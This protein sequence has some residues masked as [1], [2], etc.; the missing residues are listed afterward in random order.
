[1]RKF[2]TLFTISIAFS[3]AGYAQPCIP[4]AGGDG[5]NWGDD[6]NDFILLGENNT[7]IN[8]PGTG[9]DPS[10]QAYEDYT[11][12]PAV[13]LSQSVTYTA[14]VST[15]YT[16]TG[17]HLAIWIDFNDDDIF[18]NNT[19]L[20]GTFYDLSWMGSEVEINIPM[21]ATLG[22]HRM[23]ASQQYN[24][25]PFFMDPC[26]TWG[27]ANFTESHDY[28]VNIVGPPSCPAI[29]GLMLTALTDVS[30]SV[31]WTGTGAP[32]YSV[33]YGPEGFTVG[34]GTYATTP[35]TNF[36]IN[37]L[38]E[39]TSYDV[40]VRALCDPTDSSSLK[41][42]D[43]TTPCSSV[44]P[45]YIQPFDSDMP[46]TTPVCMT[47][48]DAN[49]D[50]ATWQTDN[51]QS[52]SAPNSLMYYATW[53][54]DADDWIFTP[55]INM[56]AN[57][58][59]EV[60]FKYKAD[61]WSAESL[62]VKAGM[63][64][65]STAMGPTA[66]FSNT[67]ITN[68]Q[69]QTASFIITPTVTGPQYIGWHIFSSAFANYLS[70]ED[71]NIQKICG[72]AQNLTVSN[73]TTQGADFN[74]NAVFNVVGYEYVVDQSS[75]DPTVTGIATT[76]TSY[77]VS[78][79]VPGATYYFH[80]RTNCG[81]G[82]YSLWQT[83][84]FTTNSTTCTLPTGV[85]ASAITTNSA[86]LNWTAQPG[87]ISYDYKLDQ[88]APPPSSGWI[89][90]SVTNYNASGLQP[91]TQYYFH[92]RTHCLYGNSGW[93]TINFTTQNTTCASPAN[94]VASG[95]TSDAADLI[96]TTVVGAEGYEYVL[97]QNMS[98]PT[99]PGT[100]T[101]QNIYPASGLTPNTQ[102]Y[103]HLRSDCGTG[104]SSWISEQ[105]STSPLGVANVGNESKLSV[106]PNPV[107]NAVTVEASLAS[108]GA[109]V[110]LM[111]ISGRILQTVQMKDGHVD[112]DMAQM[113]SGMYL[114]KLIDNG[115]NQLIRVMKQ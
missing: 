47:P 89:S 8:T 34:S 15:D 6:I 100:F 22:V 58:T 61:G 10:G 90:S 71:I 20:V 80:L 5:C 11:S 38:S 86:I 40:Y 56:I 102:Y 35:A 41:T 68:D 67:G 52:F 109:Q 19:E 88:V 14:F 78:G 104:F 31:S 96:W 69:Y 59:Y 74:W 76:G 4:F 63:A 97:D 54:M 65:S 55:G 72:Q 36:T 39:Q 48:E 12:L 30:A 92:V 73:I 113:A 103:F 107:T 91:N 45:P 64:P 26:N 108:D 53:N 57:A 21:T 81:A 29:S 50:N 33:E 37:G 95:I 114:I 94:V 84:S 44:N 2:L 16:S 28:M 3:I 51:W 27:D 106:Y 25:D 32:Q 17:D 70:I 46:F 75:A 62:E 9:C 60:T 43:F 7:E 111:D 101:D 93:T 18:D 42:I 99:G 87:A 115:N 105:F 24:V 110:Q 49:N 112:I 13:D 77:T 23:R 1:M 98:D 79:L 66:Y 82:E 83:V 85:A